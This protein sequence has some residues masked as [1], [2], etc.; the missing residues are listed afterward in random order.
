[1]EGWNTRLKMALHSLAVRFPYKVFDIRSCDH[2]HDQVALCKME[3]D[4]R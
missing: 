1:M 3:G 2:S 4:E